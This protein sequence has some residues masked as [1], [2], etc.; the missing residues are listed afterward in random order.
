[1]AFVS[2]CCIPAGRRLLTAKTVPPTPAAMRPCSLSSFDRLASSMRLVAGRY[3]VVPENMKRPIRGTTK[4]QRG[5]PK[6]T[7]SGFSINVRLQ[8]EQLEHLDGW[9]AKQREY[10]SR[11]EAIR[12][13]LARAL[14][15]A[16]PRQ[17]GPH[18]G[19]SKAAAMAGK[20]LDRLGDTSATE[21]QRRSRKRKLLK[22]PNEF[23][24]MREDQP[25]R[26]R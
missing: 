3:F 14:K 12:E 7:G 25:K 16:Q 20:E 8:G 4:R 10:R 1:M 9:I 2:R 22:G 23:R 24:G 21:E 19:A 26:K 18:K 15:L 6:T 13:I 11:P 5:R 17:M